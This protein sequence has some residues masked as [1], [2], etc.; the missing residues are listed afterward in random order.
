MSLDSSVVHSFYRLRMLIR[1]L[2]SWKESRTT[3]GLIKKMTSQKGNLSTKLG[4]I[5]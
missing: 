5:L 3:T 4:R 1:S 2:P